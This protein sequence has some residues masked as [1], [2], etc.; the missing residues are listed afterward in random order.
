MH[1]QL[2]LGGDVWIDDAA[3]VGRHRHRTLIRAQAVMCQ[4]WLST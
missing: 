2:E 4:T 1:I 3:M